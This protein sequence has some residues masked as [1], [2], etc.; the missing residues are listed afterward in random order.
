MKRIEVIKVEFNTESQQPE[1]TLRD[2]TV[3]VVQLIPTGNCWMEYWV[4]PEEK[5]TSELMAKE[6][7]QSRV[8]HARKKQLQPVKKSWWKKLAPQHKRS[9]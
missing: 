1:L 3:R 9:V 4:T 8:E 6:A 5:E 7:H 2:G